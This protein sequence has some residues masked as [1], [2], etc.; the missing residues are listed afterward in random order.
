MQPKENVALVNLQGTALFNQVDVSLS[1]TAVNKLAAPLHSYKTYINNILGFSEEAKDT[2]FSAE[3]FAK[4]QAGTFDVYKKFAM[5]AVRDKDDR[6][7]ASNDG[8]NTRYEYTKVSR[9]CQL[10][11]PL[12]ID[13]FKSGH[14]IL[15]N[16]PVSIRLWQSPNS[17]RIMAED[18]I[19]MYKVQLMDVI[20]KIDNIT[21]PVVIIAHE[22]TLAHADAMY[23]YYQSEFR[24]Y[25]IP[26][27]NRNFAAE[28]VF[29]G[30]VPSKAFAMLVNLQAY[31]SDYHLSPYNFANYRV[32]KIV[33]SVDNV[34]RPTVNAQF[35]DYKNR[36]YVETYV[37]LYKA[38]G[39]YGKNTSCD[40]IYDE[41]RDSYN[42]YGWDLVHHNS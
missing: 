10:E 32:N 33:F 29:A 18:K 37:N 17:F 16:V 13:V 19:K 28:N 36:S 14:Y 15:N 35:P 8:F 26:F 12:D 11:A 22:E 27:E 3:L 39:H 21:S 40:I 42:I 34:A 5:D 30:V 7:I 38:L 6:T 1:H 2:W 20:L 23:P 31:N 24:V 41:F 4:Y 9:V 25:N